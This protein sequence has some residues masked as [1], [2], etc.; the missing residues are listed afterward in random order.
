MICN[1]ANARIVR[2]YR[3][4]MR[5]YAIRW[6]II[7]LDP[8]ERARANGLLERARYCRTQAQIFAGYPL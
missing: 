3:D 5:C 2:L 7:G 4:I 1:Q 6:R 8:A